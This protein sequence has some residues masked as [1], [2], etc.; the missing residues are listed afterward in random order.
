MKKRTIKRTEKSDWILSLWRGDNFRKWGWY[1]PC[2]CGCDNREDT[3]Y[4][5]IEKY[6]SGGFGLFGFSLTKWNVLAPHSK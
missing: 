2:E 6:F 4:Y 3:P 1:T 5:F